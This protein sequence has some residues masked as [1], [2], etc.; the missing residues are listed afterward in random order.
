MTKTIQIDNPLT[1]DDIEGYNN[2]ITDRQVGKT[3]LLKSIVNSFNSSKNLGHA[4]VVIVPTL[5]IRRHHYNKNDIV[6]TTTV[7][8]ELFDNLHEIRHC[9]LP[10][11]CTIYIEEPDMCESYS[12]NQH[13]MFREIVEDFHDNIVFIGTPFHKDSYQ[14]KL[15]DNKKIKTLI[16]EHGK[17]REAKIRKTF[18]D[19]DI[20][21]RMAFKPHTIERVGTK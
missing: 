4:N 11:L 2:I 5:D 17:E 13:S 15:C 10:E 20:D 16:V 6:Y 7:C 21:Y 9:G 18:L 19:S 14:M 12:N 1:L 3:T 8:K